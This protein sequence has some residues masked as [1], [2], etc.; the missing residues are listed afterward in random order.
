MGPNFN[1]TINEPKLVPHTYHGVTGKNFKTRQP[2]VWIFWHTANSQMKCR[3]LHFILA[4]SAECDISSGY[5]LCAKISIPGFP[6]Y[7]LNTG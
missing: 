2:T 6:V 4:K 1:M 3:I 7:N 5:S